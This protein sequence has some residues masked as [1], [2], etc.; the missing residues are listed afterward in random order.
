MLFSEVQPSFIWPTDAVAGRSSSRDAE[1][2]NPSS[3]RN[4]FHR[5]RDRVVPARAF[6]RLEAKTR[7]FTLPSRDHFRIA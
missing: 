6:R 7:F 2:L 1:F 4:D 5:D 3:Y